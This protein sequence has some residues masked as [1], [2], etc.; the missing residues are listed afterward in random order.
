MVW[1]HGAGDYGDGWGASG[2]G[3]TVRQGDTVYIKY[4]ADSTGGALAYAEHGRS[5]GWWRTAGPAI[6]AAVGCGSSHPVILKISNI[7]TPS[8]TAS[9]VNGSGQSGLWSAFTA[10]GPYDLGL[11]EDAQWT[12]PPLVVRE[13]SLL[14][15]L[16]GPF[17]SGNGAGGGSDKAASFSDATVH[18][19]PDQGSTLALAAVALL[20]IAWARRKIR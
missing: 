11:G 20:T 17:G 13:R 16:F 19:V 5:W 2:K 6:E 4:Y 1:N 12:N 10:P 14:E 8:S 7:G 9:W 3:V 18:A 15:R